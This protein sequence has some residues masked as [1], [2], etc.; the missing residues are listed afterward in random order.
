MKSLAIVCAGGTLI[1]IG[2]F[3]ACAQSD[4][5]ASASRDVSGEAVMVDSLSASW[6]QRLDEAEEA[7]GE[8]ELELAASIYKEALVEAEAFGDDPRLA[9]ALVRVAELSLAIGDYPDAEGYF[10]RFLEMVNRA[11]WPENVLLTRGLFGIALAY[12]A[13]GEY[14]AAEPHYLLAIE[15]L[16]RTGGEG[17]PSIASIYLQLARLYHAQASLSRAESFYHRALAVSEEA[18]GVSEVDVDS[19]LGALV[20]LYQ[21]RALHEERSRL[22]GRSDV[23][24]RTPPVRYRGLAARSE[25]RVAADRRERA[26]AEEWASV[27]A[28]RRQEEAWAQEQARR[29]LEKRAHKNMIEAIK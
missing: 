16:E 13:V 2:W 10:G 25:S 9:A 23:L 18:P 21:E 28:R 3:Y 22:R 27:R 11:E 19:V 17:C 12:H 6:R 14:E 5:Q 8:G 26:R 15:S 7:E 29:A 24:E 20:D 4:A 1:A